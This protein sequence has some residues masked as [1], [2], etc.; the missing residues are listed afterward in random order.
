MEVNEETESGLNISYQND[1]IPDISDLPIPIRNPVKHRKP[2]KSCNISNPLPQAESTSI[3]SNSTAST[4]PPEEMQST[5]QD[6]TEPYVD[7]SKWAHLSSRSDKNFGSIDIFED[8]FKFGKKNNSF[9]VKDPEILKSVSNNHFMISRIGKKA[10]IYDLSTYG[11]YLN[12]VLIGKEK[13]CELNHTDKIS[14]L[15][16]DLKAF[17]FV[18]LETAYQPNDLTKEYLQSFCNYTVQEGDQ[19]SVTKS[20]PSKVK[21]CKRLLKSRKNAEISPESK[22]T[23]KTRSSLKNKSK[24]EKDVDPENIILTKR[25]RK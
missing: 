20:K 21:A 12:N 15:N 13:S 2:V 8:I 3:N 23:R 9:L 19:S 10:Y 5:I 1:G 17:A 25:S 18:R 24:L 4:E 22:S 11:T 7:P 16:K 6:V 14:I